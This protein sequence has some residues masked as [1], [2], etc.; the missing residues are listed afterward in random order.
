MKF[1]LLL[2]VASL[3]CSCGP[4]YYGYLPGTDYKMLEPQ[5]KIDLK[6]KSF[7]IKFI[8]SRGHKDKISCSGYTL[9]RETELEGDLGANYFRESVLAMIRGANG[10]IDPQSPNKVVV[11]LEAESFK[12]IGALYIV[13]HGFTQFKVSSPFLTKTYCVDMT[14]HDEDAPLKWY[15][16]VTRR[17]GSRLMVSGATRRAAESFVKD[18]A[19][20]DLAH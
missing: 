2:V 5:E 17:T 9:D 14:D 4:L 1:L 6:G 3:L 13:A 11:E 18:L 19:E 16:L 20:N 7:D 10:K 12:L 15:S 8:D